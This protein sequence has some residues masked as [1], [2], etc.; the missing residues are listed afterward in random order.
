MRSLPTSVRKAYWKECVDQG[1]AFEKRY[2]QAE[3]E[4]NNYKKE[5]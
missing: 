4:E 5:Q 2:V 1:S 3:A